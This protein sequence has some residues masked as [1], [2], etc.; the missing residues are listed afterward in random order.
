MKKYSEEAQE[1][2]QKLSEDVDFY[3]DDNGDLVVVFDECEVA[4]GYM[5]DVSFTI[6][7]QVFENLLAVQ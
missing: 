5:K 2:F 1:D 7:R 4:P 3:F 6:K